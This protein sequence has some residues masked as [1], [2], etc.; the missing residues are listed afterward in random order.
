MQVNAHRYIVD[1][2]ALRAER[3]R[4]QIEEQ[5]REMDAAQRNHSSRSEG[6]CVC[7]RGEVWWHQRVATLLERVQLHDGS[8]REEVVAEGPGLRFRSLALAKVSV[9]VCF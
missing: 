4:D 2:G 3:D 8:E 1:N 7:S 9:F 5:V 6:G